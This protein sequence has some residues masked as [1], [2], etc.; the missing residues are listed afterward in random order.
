M[1][2]EATNDQGAVVLARQTK[3]DVVIMQVQMRPAIT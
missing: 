1:V 3:P 2:G